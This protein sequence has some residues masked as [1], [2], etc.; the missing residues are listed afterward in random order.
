MLLLRRTISPAMI[1][2]RIGGG[3]VGPQRMAA[4][5]NGRPLGDVHLDSGTDHVMLAIPGS[6]WQIGA[7]MLELSP[8]APV[9]FREVIVKP[10]RSLSA[11]RP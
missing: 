8:E 3:S 11:V 10:T 5:L 4:A 9:T 7:N 1:D 2:L 6:Q